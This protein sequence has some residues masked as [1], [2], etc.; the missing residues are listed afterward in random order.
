MR[1]AASDCVAEVGKECVRPGGESAPVALACDVFSVSLVFLMMF[2]MLS[3][4][5]RRFS[6]LLHHE[7]RLY[8]QPRPRC[9]Q[10]L[11]LGLPSSHF[12]LRNRQVK[13]PALVSLNH[14]KLYTRANSSIHIPDR[15]R[16][17][18][19]ALGAVESLTLVLEMELLG[20]AFGATMVVEGFFRAAKG[21][22]GISLN[23]GQR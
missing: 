10:A 14:P 5:F 23:F 12:F 19:F 3:F 7:G 20:R 21:F 22:G 1:V 6:L 4:S 15:D 13:H 17:C 2:L 8:S 11:Q 9:V 18:I 16:R